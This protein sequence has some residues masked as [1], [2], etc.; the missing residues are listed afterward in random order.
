MGDGGII[1]TQP[2][3]EVRHRLINAVKRALILC[4]GG[5]CGDQYR[6]NGVG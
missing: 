1:P 3:G 5:Y 4:G 2:G 6:H